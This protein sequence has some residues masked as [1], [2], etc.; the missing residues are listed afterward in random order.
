MVQSNNGSCLVQRPRSSIPTST[1]L[2]CTLSRGNQ[3]KGFPAS[4]NIPPPFFR[5]AWSPVEEN[6][7]SPFTN[8]TTN[9]PPLSHLRLGHLLKAWL[10]LDFNR[11]VPRPCSLLPLRWAS[12]AA[13]PGSKKKKNGKE[14]TKEGV[15]LSRPECQKKPKLR[16]K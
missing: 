1:T 15:S 10:Q 3:T 11:I 16:L 13:P 5:I 14:A 8:V 4:F 12:P 2:S 7:S 9:F 6:Q